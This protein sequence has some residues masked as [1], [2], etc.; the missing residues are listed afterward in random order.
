MSEQRTPDLRSQVQVRLNV[1]LLPVLVGL[2]L[3]MQIVAPFRGWL[4]LLV[5]LGGALLISFFWIRSLARGLRLT[6]EM[7]FGWAQVGDRLEERFGIE[8]R[9][10]A[11]AP[12]IELIDHSTM[13]GYEAGRGTGVGGAGNVVQWHKQATCTRRGVFTLG[14]TTLVAGDPFG[15]FSV[16]LHY[17]A[18]APFVVMPPLV[19]LPGI[20]VSPGG[21]TGEGRPRANAANRTVSAASVREYTPGD[22]LRWIHWRTSA[23]HDSLFVR[24][25]DGVPAGDWWIVLDMDEH[26]QAGEGENSTEEHGVIL[27]ASLANRG[28]RSGRAVG[29]AMHGEDLTW[30]APQRGDARRWEILHALARVSPGPRPLSELLAQTGSAVEQYASLVII[31]PA[32][33]GHWVEDLVPLMRRGIAPTVLLLDPRSFGGNGNVRGAAA[34][35]SDLE[36]AHYV[37]TSDLL[38]RAE[39]SP[40]RRGH[41]DWQV[42][43]TGR[44]LQRHPLRDVAWKELA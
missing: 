12:L 36:I 32:A 23:R 40:G 43:G 20:E 31:T 22:S 13:P 2:L 15:I 5:G 21:Q 30:L 27:A 33:D 18:T 16:T 14:P 35:L 26:V 1:W 37:I 6:R 3:V 38:D 41:Y 4:I 25:L 24:L 39:T 11:P 29:L 10:W 34:L 28:L 19:P 42:L 17:D 7:R 9:G 44:V 8:N